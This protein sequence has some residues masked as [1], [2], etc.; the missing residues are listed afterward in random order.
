VVW[1][2]GVEY[3]VEGGCIDEEAQSPE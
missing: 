1:V 3:T 2:G